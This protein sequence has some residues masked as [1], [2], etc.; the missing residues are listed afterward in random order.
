[1]AICREGKLDGR[2]PAIKLGSDTIEPSGHVRIL[3]VILS[4]DLSF[5]KHVSAVS[6]TATCFFRLRHLVSTIVTLCWLSHRE[7]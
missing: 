2:G 6:A 4:S 3:G 7:S 5:E 1:M